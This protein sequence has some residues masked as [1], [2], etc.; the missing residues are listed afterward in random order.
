MGAIFEKVAGSWGLVGSPFG[1]GAGACGIPGG[2]TGLNCCFG[3]AAT[4][5]SA[6]KI[7]QESAVHWRQRL[8]GGNLGAEFSGTQA[9]GFG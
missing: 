8:M 1:T 5:A 3:F 2:R 6:H 7:V 4:Q 9:I